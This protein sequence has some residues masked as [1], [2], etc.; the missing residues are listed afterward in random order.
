M[1]TARS[2]EFL[3]LWVERNVLPGS[4]DRD[5]ALRLAMKLD[6]DAVA[7]ELTFGD[8]EIDVAL[9]KHTYG[10]SSYIWPSRERREIEEKSLS[11]APLPNRVHRCVKFN[12]SKTPKFITV[13]SSG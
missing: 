9:P 13:M 1:M 2:A 12:S 5:Q 8:L 7:E 10:T 4:G 6:A 11:H 3:E